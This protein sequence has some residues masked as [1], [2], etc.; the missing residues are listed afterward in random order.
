LLYS[1]LLL[2]DAVDTATPSKDWP[3]VNQSDF[4]AWVS[5]FEDAFGYLIIRVIKG[6]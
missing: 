4:T 6:A 2:G 5:I 3:S 1:G